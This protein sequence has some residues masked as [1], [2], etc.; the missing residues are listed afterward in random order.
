MRAER[1]LLL[2]TEGPEEALRIELDMPVN[3]R[4]RFTQRHFLDLREAIKDAVRA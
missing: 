3:R 4:L 1:L 2:N